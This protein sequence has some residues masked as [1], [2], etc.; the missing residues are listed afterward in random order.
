MSSDFGMGPVVSARR[1]YTDNFGF[2]A[3]IIIG[4]FVMQ[5]LPNFLTRDLVTPNST[6][7]IFHCLR[8]M[9]VGPIRD[10]ETIE[11]LLSIAYS[12]IDDFMIVSR[13]WSPAVGGRIITMVAFL[14]IG[15]AVRSYDQNRSKT[16]KISHHYLTFVTDILCLHHQHRFSLG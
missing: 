7:S 11:S 15:A 8:P 16:S 10:G 2:S 3:L 14:N 13:C 12:D 9:G 4:I 6:L 1:K 5:G